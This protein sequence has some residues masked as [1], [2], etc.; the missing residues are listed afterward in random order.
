M[1]DV[2]SHYWFSTPARGE[3]RSCALF[4]MNS[5]VPACQTLSQTRDHCHLGNTFK[6]GCTLQTFTFRAPTPVVTYQAIMNISL[7]RSLVLNRFHGWR[8]CRNRTMRRS[9]QYFGGG[10]VGIPPIVGFVLLLC[11]TT[12]CQSDENISPL[13]L[14]LSQWSDLDRQ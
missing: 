4:I 9:G 1:W 3:Y 14:V 7:I 2:C 6:S 8:L 5:T 10:T 11:T 12:L 13:L